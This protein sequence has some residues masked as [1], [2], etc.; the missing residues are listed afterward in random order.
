VDAVAAI[1]RAGETGTGTFIYSEAM[2]PCRRIIISF[3]IYNSWRARSLRLRQR[4]LVTSVFILISTQS[5]MSI[6]AYYSTIILLTLR[7]RRTT[8]RGNEGGAK[9]FEVAVYSLRLL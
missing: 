7:R 9:V 3:T 6:L 5:Y 4:S 2:A 8:L 1:G